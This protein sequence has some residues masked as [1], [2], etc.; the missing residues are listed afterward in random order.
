MHKPLKRAGHH[1]PRRV[2]TNEQRRALR[3]LWNDDS[4]GVRS[5]KD[6]IAWWLSKFG[7]ELKCS[8]C[9]DI[10]SAKFAHLDVDSTRPLTAF[11]LKSQGLDH[12]GGPP[13]KL[14]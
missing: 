8:T 11:K 3:Q 1:G 5:Q 6:A 2:A 9:S 7:W 4:Y 10:L 13:L 14:L 12:Q